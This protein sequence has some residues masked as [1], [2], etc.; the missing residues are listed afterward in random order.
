MDIGVR[1]FLPGSQL[2]VRPVRN[3]KS[4]IGQTYDF[5]VIKVSQK[6]GNIVLS[7]RVILA[8]EM[9]ISSSSLKRFR[10]ELW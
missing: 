4:F 10:K 2:D 1:A 7:R 9:D 6:R 5:K 8:K 3:I